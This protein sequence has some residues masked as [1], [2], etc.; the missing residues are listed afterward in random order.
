M[1][2]RRRMCAAAAADTSNIVGGCSRGGGGAIVAVE[3]TRGVMAGSSQRWP[4]VTGEDK[5]V[6]LEKI[7]LCCWITP[8]FWSSIFFLQID[9]TSNIANNI[10]KLL[11]LL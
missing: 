1:M 5:V 9:K 4:R 3:V 10:H 6:G 8:M 7:D 11:E 2:L